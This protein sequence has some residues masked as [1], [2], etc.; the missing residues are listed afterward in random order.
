VIFPPNR[1]LVEAPLLNSV[2][3]ERPACSTADD[4]DRAVF[5]DGVGNGRGFFPAS[6]VD[7]GESEGWQSGRRV[8]GRV[9]AVKGMG[10]E[11]ARVGVL[12]A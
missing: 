1:P 5:G 10:E 12:V 7:G 8:G 4:V 11:A 2:F 3:V 6:F 9:G